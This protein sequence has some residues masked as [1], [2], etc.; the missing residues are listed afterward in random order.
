[1]IAFPFSNSGFVFI[2]AL[3]CLFYDHLGESSCN[4][5]LQFFSTQL[6]PRSSTFGDLSVSIF[7]LNFS[8]HYQ[9]WADFLKDYSEALILRQASFC[10]HLGHFLCF[11]YW[12]WDVCFSWI[13]CHFCLQLLPLFDGAHPPVLLSE[14]LIRS[15]FFFPVSL[16]SVEEPPAFSISYGRMV[17]WLYSMRV[18]AQ[19]NKAL[20]TDK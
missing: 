10:H 20:S 4:N 6:S 1:M 16:S 12:W 18:Q 13:L 8:N 15:E 17:V 11:L 2:I 9:S 19:L 14:D 7:F 5:F 3:F